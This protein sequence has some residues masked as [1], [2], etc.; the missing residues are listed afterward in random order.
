MAV[1]TMALFSVHCSKA[2]T[3]TSKVHTVAGLSVR[4]GLCDTRS[5]RPWKVTDAAPYDRPTAA[6]LKTRR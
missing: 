3:I 6:P 2:L 4:P 1:M 5:F